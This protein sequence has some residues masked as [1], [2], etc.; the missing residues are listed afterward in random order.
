MKKRKLFLIFTVMIFIIVIISFSR[1]KSGDINYKCSDATWHTILTLKSYDETSINE[2]K[3][4]PIVSLGEKDDKYIPWGATVPDS[5]GNYYYTSFSPAG[6]VIPYIFIKIFNLSI[7]ESSLYIFNSILLMLSTFLWGLLLYEIYKKNKNV[8]IIMFI[9]LLTF[10]FSP[11]ILHGMGI[12]YWHQSVMQVT[13]LIQILSYYKMKNSNSKLSKIVFYTF[14]LINPYIEWTG[15]VANVGFALAE[16]I[17][18]FKKDKKKAFFKVFI[19]GIITCLSFCIFSLH[20]L[21]VL[22]RTL[23]FRALKNRFMSRN[24]SSGVPIVNVFS[25]YLS[26]FLYL[27]LLILI[28]IIWNFIKNK[29]IVLKHGLLFLVLFFPVLENIIMSQHA[30]QYSYDRMKLI[31]GISFLICELSN[32][33]F[34][35]NKN[36]LLLKIPLLL[37]VIVS[38][39][40]NYKSYVN[41]KSY[42]WEAPQ[43]NTNEK[44]VKYI[45]ENYDNYILGS[46]TIV[47]GYVNMLFEK[48]IYE[49]SN[50]NHIT[51]IAKQKNK[52]YAILVNF[53]LDYWNMNKIENILVY[54]IN[55]DTTETFNMCNNNICLFEDPS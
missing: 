37:I 4:L 17:Y 7:S 14:S 6:Y 48:G 52:D 43:K 30:I 1:Y 40:L 24:V 16:F 5:K 53:H 12:V 27:W 36:K 15:Y 51:D 9:G 54:S 32:N 10:I 3:F 13:L 22:D 29:K 23:F 19:L 46:N 2:H 55:D 50:I 39:L 21:T 45:N 18:Y 25:G 34:N 35:K 33:L 31:F 38:C 28:L 42:I 47:R 11:E 26:S 41:D 8:F 49:I 20:Y 44:F